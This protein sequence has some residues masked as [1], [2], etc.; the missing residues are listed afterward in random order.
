MV[1]IK[2]LLYYCEKFIYYLFSIVYV[3]ICSI[4]QVWRIGFK[5]FYFAKIVTFL[6]GSLNYYHLPPIVKLVHVIASCVCVSA[7]PSLQTNASVCGAP[8][9]V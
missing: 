3:S 1:I 9:Y 2:V 4:V 7:C 8:D 5:S 6:T